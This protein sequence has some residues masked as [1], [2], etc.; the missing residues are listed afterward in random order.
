[1][2]TY[3]K[4][5]EDILTELNDTL[6]TERCL[7][8]RAVSRSFDIVND[9]TKETEK[10]VKSLCFELVQGNVSDQFSVLDLDPIYNF[11]KENPDMKK[12]KTLILMCA[13]L[14]KDKFDNR[15]DV[16]RSTEPIENR[17]FYRFFEF[18]ETA[19][20][21]PHRKMDDMFMGYSLMEYECALN[22]V[23]T[24]TISNDMAKILGK[25]EEEL[26]K[27]AQINSKYL[28]QPELVTLKKFFYEAYR[29]SP[30]SSHKASLA[31][32]ETIKNFPDS[33]V[34]WGKNG[35]F[36]PMEYKTGVLL[37]N[38]YLATV[39]M[40]LNSDLFLFPVTKDYL[41]ITKAGTM[42]VEDAATMASLL[43][44]EYLKEPFPLS[45][46]VY[47]YSYVKNETKLVSSGKGIHD[48]T[49]FLS[50][51]RRNSND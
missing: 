31:A 50:R 29:R 10:V 32:N 35:N 2:K 24:T 11:Y 19:K 4:F 27:L 28:L 30:M 46:A 45:K 34:V 51:M 33:Y 39:A 40:K 44:D 15:D 5:L 12:I 9:K 38:E 20:Y 43:I 47:H 3:E 21:V 6:W 18:P 36:S 42:T 23:T 25:S 22:S 48:I 26:F 17:I 41:I 49:G 1:M 13:G 8:I 16:P 37:E 14:S 7:P